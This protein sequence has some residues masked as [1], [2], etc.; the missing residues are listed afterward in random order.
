MKRYDVGGD[1]CCGGRRQKA[2]WV[3]GGPDR[4]EAFDADDHN[5]TAAGIQ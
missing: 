5:D 4:T 2:G 1:G 3:A